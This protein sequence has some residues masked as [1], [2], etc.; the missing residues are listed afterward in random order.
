M[1]HCG[2]KILPPCVAPPKCCVTHT[3]ENFIQPHIFPS[4][5][6][7]VNHQVIQHQN[8]YPHTNSYVNEVDN[9]NVGPAFGP[10]ALPG[11]GPFPGPYGFP[12]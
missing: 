2:P 3:H 11:P 1:Y 6:T 9:V 8:Y 5:T 4:H 10:G 7:H 12:R